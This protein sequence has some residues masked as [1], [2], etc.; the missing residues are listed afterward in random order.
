MNKCGLG[1]NSQFVSEFEPI[2][3]SRILSTSK[4]QTNLDFVYRYNI[5]KRTHKMRHL[6][7]SEMKKVS[8][9]RA[10]SL[11]DPRIRILMVISLWSVGGISQ[12]FRG[13]T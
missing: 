3:I 10:G 5:S 7:G 6:S 8:Q 1:L 4:C 2:P 12:G 11:L 13:Y 9:W